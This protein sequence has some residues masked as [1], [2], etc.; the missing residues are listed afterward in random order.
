MVKCVLCEYESNNLTAHL[1]YAHNITPK[2]YKSKYP[3]AILTSAKYKE[4]VSKLSKERWQQK[5]YHEKM[6][7]SR[8]LTHGV[9]SDIQ[10]KFQE[11]LKKWKIR[12]GKKSWNHGLTKKDHPS[13]KSTG[14]KNSKRYKGQKRPEWVIEK[15]RINRIIKEILYPEKIALTRK[16]QSDIM[17][18]RVSEGKHKWKSKVYKNGYHESKPQKCKFYFFSSLEENIMIILDSMIEEDK[19]MFWTT[20]HKIRI[21]YLNSDYIEKFYIPDFLIKLSNNESIIIEAKPWKMIW[22]DPNTL[23]KANAAMKIYKNSYYICTSPD[24][25][26][27]IIEERNERIKN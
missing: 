26:K 15:Q 1:R 21:T 24:E 25:V 6:K 3:G 5:E 2:E 7:I 19:I 18:K 12:N 4:N 8:K 10:A 17:S 11:G 22:A 20:C 23:L 14:E 16:K 13:L 27:L 9:G